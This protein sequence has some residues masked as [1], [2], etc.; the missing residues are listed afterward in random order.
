M[1]IFFKVLVD[2][3]E[4][5]FILNIGDLIFNKMNMVSDFFGFI[6]CRV[7]IIFIGFNKSLGTV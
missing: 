4:K 3:S 5:F 1:L 6:V 2:D 7:S